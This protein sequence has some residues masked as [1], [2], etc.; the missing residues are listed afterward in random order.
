MD[1]IKNS[2]SVSIEIRVMGGESS[3]IKC[4]CEYD[5]KLSSEEWEKLSPVEQFEI[6]KGIDSILDVNLD[7]GG[8]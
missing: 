2:L 7:L 1:D 6:I 5:R 4:S 3:T 8:G